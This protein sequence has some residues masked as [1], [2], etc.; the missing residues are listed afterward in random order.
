MAFQS[1]IS[2]NRIKTKKAII[3]KYKF[4][5]LF[6]LLTKWRR[7][8]VFLHHW[9]VWSLVLKSNKRVSQ[10]PVCRW[11]FFATDGQCKSYSSTKKYNKEHA[12]TTDHSRN[13]PR[14]RFWLGIVW[15]KT[16]AKNHLH[17]FNPFQ[18]VTFYSYLLVHHKYFCTKIWWKPSQTPRNSRCWKVPQH[19]LVLCEY[20]KRSPKIRQLEM[21]YL[22]CQTLLS[23]IIQLDRHLNAQHWFL[24]ILQ[25]CSSFYHKKNLWQSQ[26]IEI[27]NRNRICFHFPLDARKLLRKHNIY[28]SRHWNLIR[29]GSFE[30]ERFRFPLQALSDKKI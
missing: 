27:G 5:L 9:G 19:C 17:L 12:S 20:W 16:S 13:V 10:A 8:K 18:R 26:L 30:S 6:T 4:H 25:K 11:A 14:I 1:L 29:T 28:C 3:I 24:E 2:S 7:Y 23:R 22:K 15:I 21:L